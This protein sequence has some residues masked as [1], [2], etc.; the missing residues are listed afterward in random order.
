MGRIFA[1]EDLNAAISSLKEKG[2]ECAE[3]KYLD[4]RRRVGLWIP[5]R[6]TAGV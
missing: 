5:K 2:F 6:Q 4:Y 1:E 3:P